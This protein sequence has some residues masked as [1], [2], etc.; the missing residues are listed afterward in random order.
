VQRFATGP[1]NPHAGSWQIA[2]AGDIGQPA[3]FGIEL[4]S[5]LA[6]PATPFDFARKSMRQPFRPTTASEAQDRALLELV[7]LLGPPG[8]AQSSV[9][10]VADANREWPFESEP[11]GWGPLNLVDKRLSIKDELFSQ[12]NDWYHLPI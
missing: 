7:P 5:P 8:S 6:I 12:W 10:T 1:A 3:T 4:P 9:E 2:K 11:T